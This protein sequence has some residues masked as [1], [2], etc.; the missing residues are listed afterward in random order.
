[1]I[2]LLSILVFTPF[3]VRFKDPAELLAQ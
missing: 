3:L 1:M 2:A